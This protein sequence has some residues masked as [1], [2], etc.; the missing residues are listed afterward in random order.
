MSRI[1]PGL[2]ILLAVAPFA[3]AQPQ[4][5][6]PIRLTV[7]PA[8]LPGPASSYRLLPDGRDLVPGNAAAI[9]Y[10]SMAAFAENRGLLDGI[11][12]SAWQLWMTMPL[13]QLPRA[14]IEPRLAEQQY[15]LR[16]LDQAARCR[17]CDWQLNGRDEG[18]GL[19]LPEV[20]KFRNVIRVVVVRAR[21]ELSA[22]RLPEALQALQSGYALSHSMGKGQTLIH[23]LV[24]VA[25]ALILDRE[26]DEIL[27]QPGAPN[28][29]WALTVL[30]RPFFDPRTAIDEEGTLLLRSWPTLKLL[31]QGPM[32]PYQVRALRREIAQNVRQFGLAQPGTLDYLAQTWEQERAYPEARRRLLK[33]GLSAEDLDG[34]PL[35][36]VVALD[37]VR[38]Y[39]R[40]WDEFARWTYVPDFGREPGYKQSFARLKQAAEPLESLVLL[41][42]QNGNVSVF[43]PPPLERIY[44]ATGRADRRFAALRCVEAIRLYAAGHDGR[45]PARL[46]DLTEV[47]VPADPVTNRPF[48]YEAHADKAK[49][50]APLQDGDK[51]PPYERLTYDITL[52]RHG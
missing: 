32:T 12:N 52:R 14:E 20:Q 6:E 33:E 28:L 22:G 49:L 40:A 45:P 34:M 17:D 29:Y 2:L 30:P 44:T 3:A 43:Q 47:P 51:T 24:G 21:H 5:G 36:Q 46:A 7:S 37:A 1:F 9:Y 25:M 50:T 42:R 15:L 10:R 4:P 11:N 13:D 39:R 27:Q 38:R 19:L 48:E 35:L 26:L 18:A 31:E 16:E 23:V 41:P 8:A